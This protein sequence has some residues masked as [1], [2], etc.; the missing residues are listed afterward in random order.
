MGMG[1]GLELE[2]NHTVHVRYHGLYQTL[3]FP[4]PFS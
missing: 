3:L 1:G 4:I 2:T